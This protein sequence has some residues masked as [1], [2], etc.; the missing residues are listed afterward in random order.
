MPAH[1]GSSKLCFVIG[2]RY[3]K[4]NTHNSL[5]THRV[6]KGEVEHVVPL[7]YGGAVVHP[8]G[9]SDLVLLI[10]LP[11][12]AVPQEALTVSAATINVNLEF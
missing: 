6:L 12:V 11:L 5:I 2:I 1:L 8:A 7:N 4:N 9:L 10:A 3:H